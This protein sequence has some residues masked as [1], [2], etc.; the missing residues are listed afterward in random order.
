MLDRLHLVLLVLRCLFTIN[1]SPSLP[2]LPDPL[3]RFPFLFHLLIHP[4]QILSFVLLFS[5]RKL[6]NF[7]RHFPRNLYAWCFPNR[8]IYFDN[9]L[10]KNKFFRNWF[11]LLIENSWRSILLLFGGG[12]L[13]SWLFFGFLYY[14]IVRFSG[15]IQVRY[16]STRFEIWLT[17]ITKCILNFP[18]PKV[19][20]WIQSTW[21]KTHGFNSN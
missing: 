14:L 10:R 13:C 17:W 18:L 3:S 11:H 6:S 19:I 1:Y 8:E 21:S 12:F 16:L 7:V 20:M 15:D 9:C 5:E 2:F 4:I